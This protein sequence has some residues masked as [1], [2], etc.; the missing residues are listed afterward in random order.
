VNCL[1]FRRAIG[2]EPSLTSVEASIHQ[3]ECAGCARFREE[4]RALDGR[5]RR[6]LALD[7]PA[8][9]SAVRRPSRTWLALA[10][11]LVVA[12]L[13]ATGL[14]LLRPAP[15]LAAELLA[16]VA[17][18]PEALVATA[19][20]PRVRVNSL[21]SQFGIGLRGDPGVVVFARNCPFDGHDVPHLVVRTATGPVTVMLL[22]H[23][24]VRAPERLVTPGYEGYLLPAGR[25]SIAV[26]GREVPD[27]A[28]VARQ[29][30][31]A[32]AWQV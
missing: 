22:L 14:W 5:I 26:L 7:L 29:I 4:M 15:T 8:G 13:A 17:H 19:P 23:R 30:E 11:S 31:A 25:G 10:A 1:E 21:L 6:A 2:A 27:P 16:H 28:E 9:G 18:E 12:A 3:S 32:L 24:V 20:L